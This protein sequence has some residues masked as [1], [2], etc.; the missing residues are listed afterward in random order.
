MEKVKGF[1]KKKEPHRQRQQLVNIR[2]KGG[3]GMQKR[4][5]RGQM[6]MGEDLT[7]DVENII[8]YIKD[9]L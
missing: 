3:Q 7:L 6:V 5:N 1:G 8:Q 2:G 4:A 9:V